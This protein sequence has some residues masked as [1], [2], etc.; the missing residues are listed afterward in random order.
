[1]IGLEVD[2]AILVQ[3]VDDPLH[4]LT[5]GAKV[6]SNPR[7]GLLARSPDDGAEGSPTGVG[8]VRADDRW[9]SGRG[10]SLFFTGSE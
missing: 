4:I 3:V 1:M 5:M 9:P 6:A 10:S 7:H 2:E 8:A